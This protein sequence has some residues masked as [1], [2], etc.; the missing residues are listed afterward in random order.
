MAKLS[1]PL[2]IRLAELKSSQR[3]G[4]RF[5]HKVTIDMAAAAV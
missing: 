3:V 2:T 5:K 4:I 1:C